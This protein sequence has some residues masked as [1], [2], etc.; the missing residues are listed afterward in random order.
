MA[1]DLATAEEYRDFLEAMLRAI[2]PLSRSLAH[3]EKALEA[4]IAYSAPHLAA[5]TPSPRKRRAHRP[6]QKLQREAGSDRPQ[7]TL[8][9]CGERNA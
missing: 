1:D 4:W 8:I 7:L 5:T 9:D 3:L 6:T 2:G